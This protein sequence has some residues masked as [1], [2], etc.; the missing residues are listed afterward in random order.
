[1]LFFIFSTQHLLYSQQKD[2]TL[3]HAYRLRK[4]GEYD[5][6]IE[7]AK[8]I[9][10]DKDRPQSL[11]EAS[12]IIAR[13]LKKKGQIG[14]ALNYYDSINKKHKLEDSAL[15]ATSRHDQA[16]ILSEIGLNIT[17]F[18]LYLQAYDY[19]KEI[20]DQAPLYRV[21]N[22]IAGIFKKSGDYTSASKYYYE[23][24]KIK[25]D[26]GD[27]KGQGTVYNNL[28][29]MLL[30]MELY[31]SAYVVLNRALVLRQS[32][33]DRKGTAITLANLSEVF[34][35]RGDYQQA[36]SLLLKSIALREKHYPSGVSIALNALAE[37]YL[38]WGK[39]PQARASLIQAQML[40]KEHLS[41][42]QASRNQK[43][44]YQFH[45]WNKD[46][47][48]ALSALQNH[49][50]LEDSL[51]RDKFSLE[52][53]VGFERERNLEQLELKDAKL[54]SSTYF[55]IILTIGS[56]ALLSVSILLFKLYRT[57]QKQKQATEL[58]M[59]EQHHRVGN[60]IAVLSTLL[61][62]AGNDASSEE[63]KSLALEGKSR[64]EA[65]NLL[66]SQLY[67]KDEK[68]TVALK[69]FI[70]DLAR[71][72]LSRYLPYQPD[73]L[74][75][76]LQEVS[77]SVTQAIPFSLILNEVLTNA[78]KYG[79]TQTKDPSLF[80]TLKST[81]GELFIEVQNNGLSEEV[82]SRNTTSPAFGQS[83]IQTL[84][85]QL[86][87]VFSLDL[88]KPFATGYFQMPLH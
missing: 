34:K 42:K 85:R 33:A 59:R 36:E 54:K 32:T 43:L 12:L 49:G 50:L 39:S 45:L 21:T 11:H 72:V 79:L 53:L 7:Q 14:M 28:G 51:S 8:K 73:I 81:Q 55:I 70:T 44:W 3:I 10:K 24:L 22:S 88:Q 52:R 62:Q 86:K 25:K 37:V 1:M 58:R 87:G 41:L 16:N 18:N 66:H 19:Y 69:P 47:S 27:E 9:L 84:A 61:N 71:G 29:S 26:L 17:A 65:M 48:K 76:E 35:N 68:A 75:L 31:D 13:S 74:K 67:W 56:I 60:N 64:L 4:N 15:L 78:C 20:D 46:S 23:N 40:S 6:A 30:D 5:K 80:I 77:L 83:L 38:A 82:V 57:K 2:T 63:A